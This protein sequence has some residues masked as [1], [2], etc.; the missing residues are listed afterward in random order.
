MSRFDIFQMI[1]RRAKE[2]GL[3]YSTC[4]HTFRAT[5]IM[6][7]LLNGGTLE[8]AQTIAHHESPRTTKLYDHTREELSLDEMEKI[9]I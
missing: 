6:T 3:P 9:K 1:K 8:H 2:A 4:C 7:Y 5:G